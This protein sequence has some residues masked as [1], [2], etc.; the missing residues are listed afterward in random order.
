MNT[1][2]SYSRGK[3][4]WGLEITQFVFLLLSIVTTTA[5]LYGSFVAIFIPDYLDADRASR[6]I[7]SAF[8]A[9]VFCVLFYGTYKIK[10]WVVSL[11]LL[12]SVIGLF[13]HFIFIFTI[14]PTDMIQ[15]FQK[16]FSILMAVFFLFQLYIFTRPK[17]REFFKERGTTLVS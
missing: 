11:V 8:Y 3:L 12:F 15:L 9:I 10:R 16:V 7:E 6:L 14:N 4:P 1:P 17:T 5:T 13:N 2:N